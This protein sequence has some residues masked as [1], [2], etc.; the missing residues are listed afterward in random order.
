[1]KQ[2]VAG[3]ELTQIT[4][5]TKIKQVKDNFHEKVKKFFKKKSMK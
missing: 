3:Q 2:Y 1:M 5:D 4:E